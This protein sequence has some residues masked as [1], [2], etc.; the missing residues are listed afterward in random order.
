[1]SAPPPAP[2]NAGPG[3]G[4]PP[5]APA[6]AA[7]RAAAAKLNFRVL[8]GFTR[9]QLE[10]LRAQINAFKK[11]KKNEWDFPVPGQPN[12]T[13]A[14]HMQERR[15]QMAAIASNGAGSSSPYGGHHPAGAAGAAAQRAAGASARSA[16]GHARGGGGGRGRGAAAQNQNQ[17]GSGAQPM[18]PRPMPPSV[19]TMP[20][21]Y[22]AY[23]R[24]IFDLATDRVDG[25]ADR[26]AAANH[27]G[28]GG[29]GGAGYPGH[30]SG[31]AA[32][33]TPVHADIRAMLE[34]EANR[35]LAR[36]R[37]ARLGEIAR[38][39]AALDD[40]GEERGNNGLGA[41][42]A[43]RRR[44][45]LEEK[46]LSLVGLQDRVR[47]EVVAEQREL[48]EMGER[49][50]RKLIREG[51]KQR[52][53]S[54]RED[55][56]RAKREREEHFRAIKDWRR[57]IA[58]TASDARE[59]T[60]SRNRAVLKLHEK[61][62]KEWARK[63]REAA[64]AARDAQRERD[65]GAGTHASSADPRHNAEYLKRVEA[66]KA[67]DMEAYRKLLAEARGREGGELGSSAAYSNDDRYASL[68]EFLEKT[69][70]YL[71][72]L[73][74]KIA[75]LKLDQQRSEAAATAAAE[76]EA[77]GA[78]EEEV[79]EA[80][81]RAADRAAAKGG[82]DL[83]D[84]AT[85]EEGGDGKQKYYAL[86]HTETE[87]ILR[88]PRMLTA[89]TLRDYQLVSLQWMISLYNNR[90]NG[91][92]ADEM[93]LGKTVQV[94]A[95]IAYLWESK[96]NYG[97][98]LIIVPNAV[99]VNWKS[100]IKLWLKNMQAVYYVGH[101]EERAKIFAQHVLPLK[102]NVLVTTYEFIMR[103]RAKLSKVN[104]QYV[105]I[106][107]A[108]RLK[109]REGRLSRDLDKF[110]CNR[111][112]LLTGTPLQNDLNELW[113]L[114]NLLLPQVFDNAKDFQRWFGDDGKKSAEA[115]ADPGDSGGDGMDWMEK[116]KKIIV[117]SRLHQILEPFMLRRLVQDVERK[118]PP[119]VT[120]AVH[121][122]NSAYQAAVYDWVRATG[123]IRVDPNYAK[124]GLAARANF[125]GYLPLQN[126]CMEL[127]KVCNHPALNYPTE[128][129]GDWR[130]GAR[131][132]R[133][134][135]KLWILDRL[136]VKLRAAGHR[137]LL[138]STMTKLL[139][140]LEVYLKYRRD[141][142]KAGEGWEWCRIDGGTALD[143]REVAITEFNA[144]GSAKFLFLLSIRAAGRGLNLQTAD[145]VVVYDPDPNPKN[146]EQAVARSHRIG[147]KREVR[148][149]HLETVCD[150]AGAAIDE[151]GVGNQNEN[152]PA[153][154]AASAPRK[155]DEWSEKNSL[156]DPTWGTGGDRT[157]AESIES[158][159]RN[160]IQQQKIEMADEVI[161]AGR[162]D[163]Q[164]S[165]AERRETL[166]KLMQEQASGPARS[167]D[168]PTL[169]RLNERIARTPE[170]V[171]MFNAMDRDASLWP[172]TL[173][174]AD[175]VPA[176][177]RYSAAQRREATE[178]NAKVKVSRSEA[179]EARK[180]SARLAASGE[181]L[182]RGERSRGGY[183]P[184]A[185]RAADQALTGAD[186]DAVRRRAADSLKA[187]EREE[188]TK[189]AAAAAAEKAAAAA[190]AVGADGKNAD[191]AGGGGGPNAH[192]GP[193]PDAA[194][195]DAAAD[196][197][198]S[199][200]PG[201]AADAAGGGGGGA[202][203]SAAPSSVAAA[204]PNSASALGLDELVVEAE[205]S[206]V[207]HADDEL[208]DDA[209]AVDMDVGDEEEEEEEE[210]EEDDGVR[211]G[212]PVEEEEELRPK[213]TFSFKPKDPPGA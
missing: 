152:A 68:Q 69:E 13:A 61:M 158:V 19:T 14:R 147:Q 163:Q 1:M 166:E 79:L 190:A 210:E 176:F 46:A 132:V 65:G 29:G 9:E 209:G 109:D 177:V 5:G 7:E 3:P 162:F 205:D 43:K 11:M 76:A 10:R 44:L 83:L 178:S 213:L 78:T 2:P 38:A 188:A 156:D 154:G 70:G 192:A 200:R 120:V 16:A 194:G 64:Q 180:A 35:R 159:V 195:P 67:N 52:D 51:E 204:D 50:Y 92:L 179:E 127:R 30:H 8:S 12:V 141:H 201:G 55:L 103:D 71:Q 105:V 36:K 151:E 110:R 106:D 185:Y 144:P 123:T 157:F 197:A 102:F 111:R 90:L 41:A 4:A 81:N 145:T 56:K 80:A 184:G 108:Q 24:P 173:A 31:A 18:P 189:E 27:R 193:G 53:I 121:C 148:C 28:G 186:A 113:S 118:L 100:E 104:W 89:G 202:A 116:E 114:L 124:I 107:E 87:R 129:G 169:R 187:K 211:I 33:P 212:A 153:E 134:C 101:R 63:K 58:E 34:A 91:I 196:A 62:A 133:A 15:A 86:A 115:A 172:G 203:A 26:E 99:I 139:D 82:K 130:D 140:L 47:A 60:V 161:N 128:K 59:L 84:A 122:P 22:R 165:H 198:P 96:Q 112:L 40:D 45:R 171:E 54:A 93:G 175:D 138:F 164:T 98:H 21:W 88:Q 17:R 57:V 142:T 174:G 126:R 167:C 208:D 160:V 150:V 137:V 20:E 25:P 73:G 66:L 170:E 119:R 168:A 97:P 75:A 199:D 206:E 136:L 181:T 182:G 37:E 72:Q 183:V 6:S 125:R 149:I 94:C 143:Q 146:E 191:P 135:G 131:L 95:L 117:V 23:E 39:L 74:G 77:A 49:Q 32:K 155:E 85:A 42:H 48:M 207:T